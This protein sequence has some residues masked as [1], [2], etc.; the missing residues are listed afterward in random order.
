MKLKLIGMAAALCLAAAGG[1]Q[2][3]VK[4]GMSKAAYETALKRIEAQAEADER[5]CKRA[6]GHAKALC[7]AQAEG[8]EKAGK[9]KLQARYKPSPEAV[10]EAKFAVAEANYEVEK[11]RCEPLKGQRKDRCVAQ[12]K[13]GREAAERQARVEKVDSTGG[14]FGKDDDN[15]PARGAKS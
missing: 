5:L 2:A 13:A 1:A 9:A 7:E 11:V 6:K 15:K 14:I 12:A 8:K 3:E 4:G 10:Q